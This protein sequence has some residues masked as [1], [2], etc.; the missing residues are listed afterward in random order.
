MGTRRFRIIVTVVFGLA[1]I[2]GAAAGVLA[3]RF[4]SSTVV[5]G[6]STL[7]DLQLSP[8]QRDQMKQI[9]EKVRDGSDD[10]YN[11]A[12]QLQ[13]EHDEK[14]L[15]LLNPEQQKQFSEIYNQDRDTYS[16]LMAQRDVALKKAIEETKNLLSLD[17]RQKYDQIL[18][19][20]LGRSAEPGTVWLSAPA[21]TQP[22]GRGSP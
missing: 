1:L 4:S 18:K 10:L 19:S 8:Q 17:Q 9:W 16:R 22:V 15:K 7:D 2:A 20:R 21:A 13:R 14:I 11:Q 6:V 12:L 5:P 3:T